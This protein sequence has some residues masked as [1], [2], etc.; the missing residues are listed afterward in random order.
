MIKKV[1]LGVGHGG[2]DPGAVA[3][4]LREKDV[5][6]GIALAAKEHLERAGVE[7]RLSR[8]RDEDDALTEEIR[9]CNAYGPDLAVDIHNNAGGGDGFEAYCSMVG[10]VSRKLAENIEVRV[11][12]IGQNSRGVKTRP[13]P[14]KP[15]L[16]YYGFVR[17]TRGPAVLCEFAFLDNPRDVAAVAGPEAQEAMGMALARGILDTLGIP[18]Q[19]PEKWAVRIQ[20]F[21]RREDA[22]ETSG[23]IRA[24]GL[25]NEIHTDSENGKYVV[26][27]FSFSARDKADAL[28][29]IL[30]HQRY[31]VVVRQA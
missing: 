4:G 31:S 19:S 3:N 7:V 25:Y 13:Y 23:W 2:T 18:W 27:V 21:T 29:E 16:D 17:E 15:S 11:K 10:G 12:A 9:E 20:H 14:G 6:L 1:F 26:D 28:A 22:A 5:N 30:N 24:L 8:Y